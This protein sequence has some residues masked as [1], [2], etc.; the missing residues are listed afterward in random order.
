[1]HYILYEKNV[2]KDYCPGV[3]HKSLILFFN[4]TNLQDTLHLPFE[5]YITPVKSLTVILINDMCYDA[6]LI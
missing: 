5:T 3:I 1:M 2:F 4:F 6:V